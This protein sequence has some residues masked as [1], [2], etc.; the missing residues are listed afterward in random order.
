MQKICRLRRHLENHFQLDRRAEWEACD[1]IYEAA[2]ILF[3]SENLLQQFRSAVRDFRLFAE[4]S[5]SS[6][7]HAEPDDTRNF[8]ERP[9]MLP[10]DGEGIESREA[11][12][13]AP[14]FHG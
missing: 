5:R 2:R 14:R 6:D 4:I 9:Q 11:C 1:A 7:R 13:R 8:I 10:R 12:R 3:F